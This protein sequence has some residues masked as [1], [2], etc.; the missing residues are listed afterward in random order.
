MNRSKDILLL[1]SLKLQLETS[2]MN[3]KYGKLL[4]DSIQQIQCYNINFETKSLLRYIY[5]IL[6]FQLLLLNI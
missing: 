1:P 4:P 5:G 6:F 2:K 3:E